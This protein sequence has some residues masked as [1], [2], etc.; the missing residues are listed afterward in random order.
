VIKE[1]ENYGFLNIFLN[2]KENPDLQLTIDLNDLK[3]KRDFKIFTDVPS[4]KQAFI[5]I[6]KEI[7]DRGVKENVRITL[8][9]EKLNNKKTVA[10]KIIHKDSTSKKSAE[11]LANNIETNGGRFNIIYDNLRSICDWSIDTKC[12][13]EKRYKI[14]YL[15]PEIDNNK[16]HITLLEDPLEG[17]TYILRFYI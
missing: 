10:L 6:L 8:S 9:E 5:S 15:Y 1:G 3:K 13:D 7:N 16:P 4:L 14:D 12:I 17:F 11:E 2:I